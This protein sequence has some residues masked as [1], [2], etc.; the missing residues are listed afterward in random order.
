MIESRCPPNLNRDRLSLL[1]DAAHTMASA[2]RNGRNQSI[3]DGMALATIMKGAD[4]HG[5]RAMLAVFYGTAPRERVGES[6]RGEQR[7]RAAVRSAYSELG[8]KR[9]RDHR[10]CRIPQ[11]ALD[12]DVGPDAQAA[13][14][15]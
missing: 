12:H 4:G 10:A 7:E 5:P 8:V 11:A 15:A 1:G 2:S 6:Q 14:A 3:E 13:A 9:R